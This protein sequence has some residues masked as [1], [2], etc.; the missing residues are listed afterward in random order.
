[1][2][3]IKDIS[4]G[5]CAILNDGTV[6]E[7]KIVLLSAFPLSTITPTGCNMFYERDYIFNDGEELSWLGVNDTNLPYQSVK[8]FMKEIEEENKKAKFMNFENRLKEINELIS[9]KK[10]IEIAIDIQGQV[11]TLRYTMAR[12]TSLLGDVIE[13]LTKK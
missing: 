10:D 6:E 9:V 12:L 7:L 4:E 2:F 3:K 5:R 1:M 11:N 13:E 8:V